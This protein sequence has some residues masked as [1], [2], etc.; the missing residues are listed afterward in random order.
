VLFSDSSSRCSV[1]HANAY[2]NA[3]RYAECESD[4]HGNQLGRA[5]KAV[6][7]R[8]DQP[9]ASKQCGQSY[10]AQRDATALLAHLAM[11]LI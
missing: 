9:V 3:G 7:K 6:A 4:G 1:G 10:A 8:Q 11:R 5:C 2:K